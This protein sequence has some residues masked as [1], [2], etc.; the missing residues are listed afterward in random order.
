MTTVLQSLA[1]QQRQFVNFFFDNLDLEQIEKAVQ[2][3]LECQGLIVLTGVGKSGIIA[4]KIAMTLTST[5]SRA[6]YLPAANFLHGDIGAVTSQDLIFMLSKSGETQELL[7]L[8]PHVRRKKCKIVT[9]V[10][11]QE[12]RL[13]KKGDLSIYLPVEK[14]LCSFDIAPTTS[15]SVQLLFGDLLAMALMREKGF[16]LEQFAENH[17]AGSIGKK[18]TLFVSDLMKIGNE[19]PLCK[20]EDRLVDVIVE[21]S[22]KRCGCL[23]VTSPDQSFLGIFTDGDLRRALQAHGTLVL[24]RKMGDLMTKSA[25]T[26]EPDDLAYQAL[27]KMQSERFVMIAPVIENNKVVGLI[28]MHDIIHKGIEK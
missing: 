15:T 7:E 4:E 10:S 2:A 18:I 16:T 13:S 3:C 21:L 20:P 12:S 22:N 8:I 1:E 26:V 17:P 24:E 25:I 23:L 9:V 28:R 27:Q 19:L 11:D 6:L 14:E 5:G